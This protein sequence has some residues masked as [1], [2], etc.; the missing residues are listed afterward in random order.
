MFVA[1]FY[2]ARQKNS[3][4]WAF[5]TLSFILE[6]CPMDDFGQLEAH[7]LNKRSA[8]HVKVLFRHAQMNPD[9][10]FCRLHVGFADSTE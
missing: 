3:P 7:S 6:W 10:Y 5:H 1:R 9:G 4:A 8:N 2:L